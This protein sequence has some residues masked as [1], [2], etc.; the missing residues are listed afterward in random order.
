MSGYVTRKNKVSRCQVLEGITE[1]EN[2]IRN[3]EIMA[4]RIIAYS[5]L[6]SLVVC[7]R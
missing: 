6:D 5:P 4:M 7:Q 1:N 3:L 2:N